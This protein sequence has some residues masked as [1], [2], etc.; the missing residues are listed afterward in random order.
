ME[1][2]I[3]PLLAITGALNGFLHDSPP[4]CICHSVREYEQLAYIKIAKLG[5]KTAEEI[6]SDLR[7]SCHNIAL[8][9]AKIRNEYDKLKTIEWASVYNGYVIP[10]K[11]CES[12]PFYH[13]ITPL[14]EYDKLALIESLMNTT[15]SWSTKEMMDILNVNEEELKKL[16]YKGNYKLIFDL[17]E[18]NQLSE[19]KKFERVNF[20]KNLL[21]D[22]KN[23]IIKNI[24]AIDE[25]WIRAFEPGEENSTRDRTSMKDWKMHLIIAVY[26][27]Q[28][29]YYE[30]KAPHDTWSS[31]KFNEFLN[32]MNKVMQKRGISA[33][34][35]VFKSS[36]IMNKEII[37]VSNLQLIQIP[38]YSPDL[39]PCYYTVIKSIKQPLKGRKFYNDQSGLRNSLDS[40]INGFNSRP[41]YK[42][43]QYERLESELQWRCRKVIELNGTY[44]TGVKK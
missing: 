37:K 12:I 41:D 18:S 1:D 15:R 7:N 13:C 9:E 8:S 21:S 10:T 11:A 28:I 40:V 14:Q 3:I 35:I 31:N 43:N 23:N 24:V 38:S 36:P 5:G 33:K 16:L 26:E 19:D 22:F 6:T 44:F 29:I 34:H 17:W 42:F 27:G 32:S 30:L 39:N 20:C 2:L 25:T 4:D